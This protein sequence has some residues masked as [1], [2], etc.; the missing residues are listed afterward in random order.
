MVVNGRKAGTRF[1]KVG[2]SNTIE[3]TRSDTPDDDS[4]N[5]YGF[6]S[7]RVI[8]EDSGSFQNKLLERADRRSVYIIL[9]FAIIPILYLNLLVMFSDLWWNEEHNILLILRVHLVSST[10]HLIMPKINHNYQIHRINIT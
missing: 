4:G 10:P 1:Y 5:V 6:V 9:Y 2:N 8:M 7:G 3:V